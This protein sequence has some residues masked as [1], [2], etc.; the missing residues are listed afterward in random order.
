MLVR[1]DG[2]DGLFDLGANLFFHFAVMFNL[3]EDELVLLVGDVRILDG[4]A[5]VLRYR[6]EFGLG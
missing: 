2:I 6:I 5:D 3:F 1:S 4:F